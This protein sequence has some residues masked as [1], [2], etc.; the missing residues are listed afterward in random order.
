MARLSVDLNRD[1]LHQI[2]TPSGFETD[3][4]FEIHLRNHCEAIH[5]H[6]NLDDEL[7]TVAH[8]G[9]GNHYV[10][11]Y[12]SRSVGIDTRS[13]SSSVTGRLKIVT[14]YGNESAYTDV[15]ISPPG[16]VTDHVE[17]DERLA[18]PQRSEPEPST[19]RERL[20]AM[21]TDL[22]PRVATA[23]MLGIGDALAIAAFAQ[24]TALVLGLMGVIAGVFTA[25]ALTR[26]A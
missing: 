14:G 5:V 8:L 12:S 3:G 18:K 2:A 11:P 15:T 1:G 22:S 16:T 13:I 23:G 4:P 26:R 17:V 6:L 10:E 20:Q 21:V 24:N 19:P 25:L 7:S 9:E